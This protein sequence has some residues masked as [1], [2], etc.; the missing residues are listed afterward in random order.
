MYKVFFLPSLSPALTGLSAKCRE[1]MSRNQSANNKLTDG[2]EVVTSFKNVAAICSGHSS[3]DYSLP[4]ST[5]LPSTSPCLPASCPSCFRVMSRIIKRPAGR[6]INRPAECSATREQKGK[7]K[8]EER[9]G[10]K[11]RR[12]SFSVNMAG[13][14]PE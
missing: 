6:C 12:S 14:I 13:I 10:R 5:S 9:E 2:L 1:R 7:L 4:G 8:K 11:K 3:G